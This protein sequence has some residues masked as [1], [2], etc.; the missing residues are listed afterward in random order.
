M[1]DLSHAIAQME[2]L[3]REDFRERGPAWDCCPSKPGMTLLPGYLRTKD[4]AVLRSYIAALRILRA[5]HARQQP[6]EPVKPPFPMMVT[7]VTFADLEL[8]PKDFNDK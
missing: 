1:P 4:R 6:R 8:L 5:A 3:V 2:W 7:P